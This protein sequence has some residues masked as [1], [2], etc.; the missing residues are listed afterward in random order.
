MG[1]LWVAA[2]LLLAICAPLY[3]RALHDCRQAQRDNAE[4]ADSPQCA[5]ALL[6]ERYGPKQRA[7]CEAARVEAQ[8]SPWLCAAEHAWTRTTAY[9]ALQSHWLMFGLGAAAL[10]AGAWALTHAWAASAQRAL[11]REWMQQMAPKPLA[12]RSKRNIDVLE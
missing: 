10:W 6:L 8:V 3:L 9:E 2:S 1:L 5:D 11:F 7:A 4:L 12:V